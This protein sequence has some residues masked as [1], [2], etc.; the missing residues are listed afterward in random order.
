MS[1]SS[2]WNVNPLNPLSAIANAVEIGKRGL[3]SVAAAID[4]YT[5]N[6]AKSLG[7][8]SITGSIELGKSADFVVLSSDI[9]QLKPQQIRRTKIE[10]T[11]LQ[12]KIVFDGK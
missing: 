11:I 4:A 5:I 1:L 3:P 10:M 6:P 2:D 8:D 9:S 12:D 7:L